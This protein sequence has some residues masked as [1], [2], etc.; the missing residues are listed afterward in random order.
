MALKSCNRNNSFGGKNALQTTNCTTHGRIP[1][2]S[3]P[4]GL[5]TL[6]LQM[7]G[8]E[9]PLSAPLYGSGLRL[10]EALGLLCLTLQSVEGR[11]RSA[12]SGTAPSSW[13]DKRSA[14]RWLAA[15]GASRVKAARYTNISAAETVDAPGKNVRATAGLNR[16]ILDAARG[17]FTSQITYKVQLRGGQ[18]ILVNPAYTSRTHRIRGHEAAENRKTQ[19]VFTGVASGHTEDE[20]RSCREEHS[21]HAA[22]GL[23]QSR[24]SASR[25]WRRGQSCSAQASSSGEVRSSSEAGSHRSNGPGM[26]L[27]HTGSTAVGILGLQAGEDVK[28]LASCRLG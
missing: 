15:Q 9:A 11:R 28:I 18:V 13:K 1:G 17:E 26:R 6:L 23:A 19:A 5:Q 10:R 27:S 2:V 14:G 22:R 25:L 20:E 7:A 21:G 12:I 16:G 24:N 3:T 4:Q 8:T